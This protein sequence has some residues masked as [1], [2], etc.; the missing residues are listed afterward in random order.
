MVSEI[1]HRCWTGEPG[2]AAEVAAE[3]CTNKA[4]RTWLLPVRRE[5]KGE[6]D[7]CYWPYW[8]ERFQI[9]A[10]GYSFIPLHIMFEMRTNVCRWSRHNDKNGDNRRWRT[11]PY[12][13]N[14]Q[15]FRGGFQQSQRGDTPAS[16]VNWPCNWFGAHLRFAIC[17]DY[18]WAELSRA[19]FSVKLSR[20]V[21]TELRGIKSRAHEA[22]SWIWT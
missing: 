4:D 1:A 16:W 6:L 17:A 21:F 10:P 15:R 9:W 12:P 20:A 19:E 11:Y 13:N 14:I 5:T 18:N 8:G 22:G 7:S 3:D 2:A